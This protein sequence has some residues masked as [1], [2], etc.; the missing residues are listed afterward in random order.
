MKKTIAK[1]KKAGANIVLDDMPIGEM[2]AQEGR[3]E[4]QGREEV[5]RQ[6]ALTRMSCVSARDVRA[7]AHEGAAAAGVSVACGDG[8]TAGAKPANPPGMKITTT[9]AACIVALLALGSGGCVSQGKYD[10]AV[11]KTETTRAQLGQTALAL[12]RTNAELGKMNEQLAA[13]RAEREKLEALLGAESSTS[14]ARVAELRKRVDELKVAQAAAESRARL[15]KDL[16]F[17]LKE[18]VD[19]GDLTIAVRDDRMVLQLPNDVLFDTGKTDVKPNGQKTLV[20]VAGVLAA[21]SE[22]HFQVAGH[23]DDVPIHNERFAS[24]WEL[25]SGRALRVVHL[26]VDKGVPAGLL[27]AAGYAEMD[28]LAPNTTPET[29]KRNRRIEITVQP[30][31]QEIVPVPALH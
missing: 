16:T 31:I 25:S 26:L 15:F 12:G 23:T 28:P 14:T 5:G 13:T 10:E 29:R 11:A 30:Q 24:N 3:R 6:E 2:G 9:T 1:A 7:S 21:M 20:A 17:R 22:R 18:Q 8:A 27:S 4:G 19:A